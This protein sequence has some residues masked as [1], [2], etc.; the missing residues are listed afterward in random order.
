MG[1]NGT[2]QKTDPKD[3]EL[4]FHPCVNPHRKKSTQLPL[5]CVR[6]MSVLAHPTN[7]EHVSLDE[8]VQRLVVTG[9]S[10]RS[11][12]EQSTGTW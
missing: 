5:N 12:L 7:C 3:Q 11:L 9:Q 6:Q 10:R 1:K 4:E 8:R 2:L